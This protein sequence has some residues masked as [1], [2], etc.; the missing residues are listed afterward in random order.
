MWREY[1]NSVV[2]NT[3]AGERNLVPLII[4]ES[5]LRYKMKLKE[6]HHHQAKLRMV[7]SFHSGVS[8]A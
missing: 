8:D 5:H 4:N 3:S 1:S 2:I 6:S 7:L